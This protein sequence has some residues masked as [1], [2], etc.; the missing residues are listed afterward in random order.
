[1][2]YNIDVRDQHLVDD[3]NADRIISIFDAL[4]QRL[5]HNQLLWPRGEFY[6]LLLF[7]LK[8]HNATIKIDHNET[9]PFEKFTRKLTIRELTDFFNGEPSSRV[10]ISLYKSVGVSFGYCGIP[11]FSPTIVP[12][13]TEDSLKE[14]MH[15]ASHREAGVAVAFAK[16]QNYRPG[17]SV[18]CE[19]KPY[20]HYILN[21]VYGQDYETKK[22]HAKM[23]H[24]DNT[25]GTGIHAS[26][27]DSA[28]EAYF[29]VSKHRAFIEVHVKPTD[30]FHISFANTGYE[31]PPCTFTYDKLR[32]T[33]MFV[34]T[35]CIHK[36]CDN[37]LRWI[38]REQIF[39]MKNFLVDVEKMLKRWYTIK[40]KLNAD[41]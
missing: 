30:I 4:C 36:F 3:D 28:K 14:L 40:G 37:T 20:V 1:M 11:L 34:P 2:V 31:C 27:Y 35:R 38:S 22:L 13:Q 41:E 33:E 29:D 9:I 16:L 5:G 10:T 39:G 17:N 32:F 18:Y 23:L 12:Y 25:C 19:C 24:G 7:W 26:S 15:L 6:N 21:E 8:E